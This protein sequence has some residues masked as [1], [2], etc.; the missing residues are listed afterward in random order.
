M[1]LKRV[2]AT[3]SLSGPLVGRL[4]AAAAAGFGGVEI[5]EGD[6]ATSNIPA[7]ELR[8]VLTDLGLSVD[9]YQPIRDIESVSDAQ[10]RL[11]LARI[12]RALDLTRELGGTVLQIASNAGATAVDGDLGRAAAQL[13]EVAEHAERVGATIAWEPIGWA[14]YLNLHSQGVEILDRSQHPALKLCLDL[15]HWA[16]APESL[17][18]V[19]RIPADRIA[20]VQMNDK[21]RMDGDLLAVSRVHRLMPGEGDADVEGY[22]AAVLATG[23]Q[24][25]LSLEIFDERGRHGD[26]RHAAL[27]GAASLDYLVARARA[28]TEPTPVTP[29]TTREPSGV[30]AVQVPEATTT[31]LDRL[32]LA[33]E[34]VS[35]GSSDRIDLVSWSAG[36][37]GT[38]NRTELLRDT[39]PV[40]FEI[41]DDAPSPA[42]DHVTLGTDLL[43]ESVLFLRAGLG[44]H[45]ERGAQVAGARSPLRPLIATGPAEHVV[46]RLDHREAG[47]GEALDGLALVTQDIR[48][49]ARRAANLGV[50]QSVPVG[51][52]DILRVRNAF[53][54]EEIA[55]Y[56]RLNLTAERDE[57]TGATLLRLTVPT[58]GVI[59]EVVERSGATVSTGEADAITLRLA[60]AFSMI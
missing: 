4:E 51:Y 33:H 40:P 5:A 6:L 31:M 38:A 35:T 29:W 49:V 2:L 55:E 42:I 25:P 47:V 59:I 1:G 3:V 28:L 19:R 34:T 56:Q 23:Y 16:C 10:F 57:H 17:D 21:P 46:A 32:G 48:T 30:A 45:V 13:T 24:G 39:S 43:D 37:P 54:D 7:R 9:L 15:F 26:P 20:I 18:I 22:F 53:T 52:F 14:R 27:V 36:D 60:R 50:A 12:D 41:T 11:N 58:P 8:D 44:L